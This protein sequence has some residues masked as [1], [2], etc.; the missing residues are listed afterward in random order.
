MGILMLNIVM[1]EFIHQQQNAY[2][3]SPFSPISTASGS[4]DLRRSCVIAGDP[5]HNVDNKLITV[6]ILAFDLTSG[7]MVTL[8]GVL[9][10]EVLG[11]GSPACCSR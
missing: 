6:D 11:P 4:S 3:S 7:V 1:G 10:I 2:L 8:P 9:D 5:R